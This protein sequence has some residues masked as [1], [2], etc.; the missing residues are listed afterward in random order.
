M[1]NWIRFGLAIALAGAALAQD[2]KTV[3]QDAAKAMGSPKTIVY[4][5]TGFNGFFGQAVQ[6]GFSWPQRELTGYTRSINYEQKSAK[7]EFV[8]KEQVFGG[9]RQNNWVNGDKAWAV[10]PNGPN[11]QLAAAEDRQLQILL[12]PHGFLQAALAASDV[13][14]KGKSERG[15]K[16]TVVSFTALGK[17]KIHGTID[18]NLVTEVATTVPN[19]LLGDMEIVCTYSGYKDF[20]GVKFPAKIKQTQ[21]G[22]AV[23]DL[24]IAEV[25]PNASVD[26]PV[27]APVQNAPAPKPAPAVGEKLADGVWLVPTSHNSL[28]IEFKDFITVIEAPLTVE[29]SLAV[30]AEA[31]RLVPNKPIK[32]LFSTHHHFDHSGGLRAYVAEGATIVTADV[33]KAYYEQLFKRKAIMAPDVLS[34]NP[35]KPSIIGVKDKYVITDGA[36]TLEM[37]TTQGDG[38]SG[39]LMIGYLP[40]PKILVEADSYSPQGPNAPVVTPPAP[41]ALVLYDNLQRLK[42]SVDQI[43]PIHGRPVPYADFPKAVGKG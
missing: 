28:V 40:K 13:T 7:E 10:G 34:K 39:E 31:K 17:Y 35:R 9:Q 11:P 21:A 8:F 2:A 25:M 14:A 15:K 38:H 1:K 22:G 19:P 24:T 6:P 43:V 27:P 37:Y 4:G 26:L 16:V 41:N 3:L 20:S 36:Q 12:T 30:I 5:G 29:R 18:A 33:N 32:Y 42:L 23:A